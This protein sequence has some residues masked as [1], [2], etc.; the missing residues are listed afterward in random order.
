MSIILW[1]SK[2]LPCKPEKKLKFSC[3]C[4]SHA[5]GTFNDFKK[6]Q[7]AFP[8]EVQV[9]PLELPGH[10]GRFDE[11]LSYD[12]TSLAEECLHSITPLLDRDYIIIGNSFGALLAYEVVHLLEK[13]VLLPN[14]SSPKQKRPPCPI[15]ACHI[16][17]KIAEYSIHRTAKQNRK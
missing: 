14:L 10:L 8:D 1:N 15:F 6:W 17:K 3:F 9:Y 13:F 5:G 11:P 12:L 7:L 4:F 16:W 2:V